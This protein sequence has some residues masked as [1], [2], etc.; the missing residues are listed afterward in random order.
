MKAFRWGDG[1]EGLRFCEG[2]SEHVNICLRYM[3]KG[4]KEEIH[5]NGGMHT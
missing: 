3:E 4:A 1:G 2:N 5:D